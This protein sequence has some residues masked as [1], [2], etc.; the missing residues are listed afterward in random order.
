M[1][2]PRFLMLLPPAALLLG[3][4]MPVADAQSVCLPLPGLLTVTPAGATTP[5]AGQTATTIEVKVSGEQLDAREEAGQPV[6]PRLLFSHPGITATPVL[7]AEGK[8]EKDRYLVS[9]TADV[10]VG[11]HDA[12][13]LTPLGISTPR[14]FS[15][16]TLPETLRTEPATGV[17]QAFPLAPGIVCNAQATAQSADHYRLEL[18]K[19]QRVVVDCA[20]RGIESKMRPV[21]IL[22]DAA[23][24]DLVAERR[25]GLLDFTAPAAAAYVVK[26]HDLSF[27]GGPDHFYRL[28]VH[29]LPAGAPLP[30]RQAAVDPV[31]TFSWPPTGLPQETATRESEADATQRVALPLDAAGR[32]FPAADVDAWEFAAEGGQTWWIEVASERIGAPTNPALVVQRALP[33]DAAET[34]WEDLLELSDIPAAIRPSTNHYAYD[35][36]PYETGSAD[37]LGKL[38]IKESGTYRILLRDLFGGTRD[39]PGAVYRLVVRRAQ[40]EFAL[41]CWP[42]HMELRNGDRAALSKPLALRGGGTVSLEVAALRRDGFDGPI[43]LAVEGLPEGVTATGLRI[44]AGA[45]RG[46]I[47]LTAA[48]APPPGLAGV[49]I[50]GRGTLDGQS[51]ERPC[52]IAGHCWPVRDGWSEIPFP[53]LLADA[54]V[55]AGGVE[56][57]PLTLRTTGPGLTAAAP[58]QTQEGATIEVPLELVKREEVQ[59]A[60]FQMRVIGPG[61]ESQPGFELDVAA[62][63]PLALDLAKLKIPP[64]DHAFALV[65]SAVT[66]HV[67]VP[68]PGQAAAAPSDIAEILVSTPI[69]VR[70]TPATEEKKP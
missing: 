6:A 38:E 68:A 51:I 59:G 23:G 48:D 55:S 65:A 20:A 5:A 9:I 66:K 17:A 67:G 35:G 27:Q 52:R 46:Q 28:L 39:E 14:V 21:V 7:S 10:P 63:K 69:H 41:V 1:S 33:G 25:G 50:L 56:G 64:G 32:F 49:R 13:M 18:Q 57:A 11:L 8:P 31:P 22:A 44:P 37:C 70:V 19:G 54:V 24:A 45:T 43:E 15:V 30:A 29:D 16:G 2:V 60:T 47:L 40:P 3:A 36:P 53:R 62:P 58:I 26:I 4:A 34:T 61:F 12:R 42:L